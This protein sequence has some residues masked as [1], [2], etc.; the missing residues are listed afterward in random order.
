VLRVFGAVFGVFWLLTALMMGDPFLHEI[1]FELVFGWIAF[2]HRSVSEMDISWPGIAFGGVLLVTGIAGLKVVTRCFSPSGWSWR[3]C[4]AAVGTV[5]I[6]FVSGMAFTG[7]CRSTIWLTTSRITWIQSSRT[8][9]RRL[10]SQNNLKQLALAAMNY[11]QQ[12]EALP[13]GGTFDQEGRG[14]HSWITHLLPYLDQAPLYR[15]IDLAQ[16]WE[17]PVNRPAT[18]ELLSIVLNPGLRSVQDEQGFP[19]SHYAGNS[20]LFGVNGS[21]SYS[22]IMDGQ[23]QTI[24]AGEV[25]DQFRPWGEPRNCRNPARPLNTPGAFGSPTIGGTHFVFADGSVRFISETISPDVLKALATPAGGEKLPPE[26]DE[27]ARRKR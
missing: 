17:A 19:L 21:R 15:R 14:R 10:Q 25:R 1:P 26:F 20:H 6:L 4:G 9:A 22:Q 23:S 8:A 27:P 12:H 16:T 11:H 5:V 24:L 7:L 2:L 3:R 13:P 18:R